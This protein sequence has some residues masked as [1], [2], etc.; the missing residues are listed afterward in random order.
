MRKPGKDKEFYLDQSVAILNNFNFIAILRT[1]S[2][3]CQ[4]YILQNFENT[5][6]KSKEL[7]DLFLHILG[8][9]YY[10]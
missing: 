8:Q 3:Y 2:N 10:I 7:L 6:E 1:Q 9:C 4:K 5:F